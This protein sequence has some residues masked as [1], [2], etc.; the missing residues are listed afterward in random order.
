MRRRK[1]PWRWVRRFL[2]LLLVL[3]VAIGWAGYYLDG[4]L[5]RIDALV[6]YPGRVADTPGTNWLLVGSDSRADLTP[7][8]QEQL[9]TGGDVGDGRTDT[10]MLVHIPKSGTPTMVSIPRD[11]YVPIPGYGTD[12]INAA[13]AFGLGEEP[14]D[15]ASPR[16]AQLLVQTIEEVTGLHIDHYGEIGFSG[17]AG[18]VDAIGGVHLCV[19]QPI[20]DPKAGINLAAGCQTL[21]GAQ[22]LG[23]VRTRSLP[24]DDFTRIQNQR[25]F[26]SALLSQATTIGTLVNPF[27]AW[28]L[29]RDTADTMRV[30]ESDHLWDLARLGWALRGDMVQ[31][32]V[33]I[34]GTE[35]VDVGDV[36]RWDSE[37]ALEFFD[38]LAND[39]PIPESLITSGL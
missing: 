24:G 7:E 1:S 2:F 16:G 17:F 9:A 26:L 34:A 13:Y 33:P 39:R 23:F 27:K 35:Y 29:A 15:P 4:K 20:D 36:V 19:D 37:R 14:D 21:D 30:D 12:K 10:I 18:L 6:A 38:A 5:H 28:P 22:A 32:T 11:S 31:T 3:V 25:K 8:Q